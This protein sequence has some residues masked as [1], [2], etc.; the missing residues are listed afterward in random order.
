MG[1]LSSFPS[2]SI[3]HIKRQ[4]NKKEDAL[5]KLASMNFLK[6]AKE[7]LV[8]VIQT[9]KKILPKDPQKTRKLAI[10]ATL[11]WMFDERPISDRFG[12][13][14]IIISDNGKQFAEGNGFPVFGYENSKLSK[15]SRLSINLRLKW[16]SRSKPSD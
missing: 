3:E 14:Q 7:V 2:Y 13:P 4:H 6:L 16:G 11:Y 5:S 12:R 8:E 10:K 15:H 9:K 1:L